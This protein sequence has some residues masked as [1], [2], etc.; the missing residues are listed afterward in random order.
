MTCGFAK[1]AEDAF[2]I[3]LEALI[4][5]MVADFGFDAP[6]AYMLLAQVLEA[7]CTQF[8]NP[9]YTYICKIRRRYLYRGR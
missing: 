8:V 5:W 1:P 2:R 3:G 7:R 9:N 6:E 4:K